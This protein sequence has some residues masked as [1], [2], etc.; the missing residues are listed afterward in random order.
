MTKRHI[1]GTW[2]AKLDGKVWKIFDEAGQLV[3]TLAQKPDAEARAKLIAMSP[4]MVEALKGVVE[5]MGDEDLP[6]NGEL[7]GAAAC[8]MARSAV[9]TVAGI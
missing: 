4:Y 9:A 3:A 5:L 7:S 6:D 8:D 1:P 2:E